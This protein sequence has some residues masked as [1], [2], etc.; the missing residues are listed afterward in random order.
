ML[1]PLIQNAR[2]ISHMS[3]FLYVFDVFF[4]ACTPD[5]FSLAIKMV[6]FFTNMFIS[7]CFWMTFG[8]VDEEIQEDGLKK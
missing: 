3:F 7:H 4:E 6:S 1:T 2:S 5:C 8:S